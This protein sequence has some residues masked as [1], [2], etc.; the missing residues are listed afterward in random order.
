MKRAMK[1][2]EVKELFDNASFLELDKKGKYELIDEQ[3]I[4]MNNEPVFFHLGEKLVPTLKLLQK[5]MVLKKI[6][7][8]MGAVPFVI[9]G[10]DIMRPGI[11]L[12]DEGINKDDFVAI[13]DEKHNKPLGVGIALFS[14]EE[15]KSMT[16]G[17]SVK[18]IHYVGDKIWNSA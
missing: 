5:S 11:K 13:V 9:K 1:S 2:K 18:N 4:L 3:V 17:K 6:T 8:D 16:N 7:V 14:G 15:M 10:A 12:I